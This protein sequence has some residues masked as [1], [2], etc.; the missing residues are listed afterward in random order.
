M[1]QSYTVEPFNP[2]RQRISGIYWNP[3]EYNASLCTC[4]A[5]EI[6]LAES[7]VRGAVLAAERRRQEFI[8]QQQELQALSQIFGEEGEFL[9]STFNTRIDGTK[10]LRTWGN[11]IA[12]SSRGGVESVTDHSEQRKL[13]SEESEKKSL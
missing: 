6:A 11:D 1:S 2:P 5:R 3:H 12:P 7:R 4:R 8:R 9:G 13:P 10:S